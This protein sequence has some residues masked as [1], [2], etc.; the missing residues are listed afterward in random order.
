M[1]TI[2]CGYCG[3]SFPAARPSCPHCGS[4][5]QTG[6]KDADEIEATSVELGGMDDDAYQDLLKREGLAP[7]RAVGWNVPLLVGVFVLIIIL[8]MLAWI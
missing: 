6:W 3:E 4:D 7:E 8:A 5:S 1:T 2:E